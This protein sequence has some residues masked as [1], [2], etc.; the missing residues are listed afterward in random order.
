VIE[1]VCENQILPCIE[2]N[3]AVAVADG[4]NSPILLIV[5]VINPKGVPITGL[6]QT[7]FDAMIKF[8]ATNNFELPICNTCFTENTDAVYQVYLRPTTNF[9]WLGGKTGLSAPD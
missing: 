5:Q 3:T 6:S 9:N 1:E 8:A 2:L 4:N 7:D